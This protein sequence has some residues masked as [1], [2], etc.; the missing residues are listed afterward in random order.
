M[1]AII[2]VWAVQLVNNW[3]SL[4]AQMLNAQEP[5]LH[6]IFRLIG[7]MAIG[8]IFA[9][10][11]YAIAIIMVSKKTR[12]LAH[13]HR[14]LAPLFGIAIG[15]C[16]AGLVSCLKKFAPSIEPFW[17]DFSSLGSYIPTLAVILD[18]MA[19]FLLQTIF[20]L[21]MIHLLNIVK[22]TKTGYALQIIIMMVLGFAIMGAQPILTLNHYFL[23]GLAVGLFLIVTYYAV[24][25]YIPAITP[26]V[27][28]TALA[29]ALAQQALLNLYPTSMTA[30]IL[31]IIIVYVAA[32]VWHRAMSPITFLFYIK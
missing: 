26:W 27:T 8:L 19:K 15:L 32:W 3:P 14:L 12:A 25:A 13:N 31:A 30:N 28:G 7:G 18:A 2:A 29:L 23:S 1:G 21:L 4:M 17:G 6:Q 10:G 24:L 20:I 11:A 9:A 16:W 5:Y 22:K